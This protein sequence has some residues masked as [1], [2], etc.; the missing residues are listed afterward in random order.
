MC[1]STATKVCFWCQVRHRCAD[2]LAAWGPGRMRYR[3][4]HGQVSAVWLCNADEIGNSTVKQV[5]LCAKMRVQKGS[6]V[7]KQVGSPHYGSGT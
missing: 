4:L 2:L 6:E 1:A 7:A 5:G 3:D